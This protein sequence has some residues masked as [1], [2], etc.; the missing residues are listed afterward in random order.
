MLRVAMELQVPRSSPYQKHNNEIKGVMKLTERWRSGG[1]PLGCGGKA[2]SVTPRVRRSVVWRHQGVAFSGERSLIMVRPPGKCNSNDSIVLDANILR[3][4]SNSS[5]RGI[6][7]TTHDTNVQKKVKP[8]CRFVS[9]CATFLRLP[10][11][12]YAS[13]FASNPS[14][15]RCVRHF[16]ATVPY[17]APDVQ[18]CR[19][20][21]GTLS[22]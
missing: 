8:I 22:R 10:R 7:W 1:V 2:Y 11:T 20:T 21:D 5:T 14:L 15:R 9:F 6:A 4:C 3:C 18:V 13:D 16:R 12:G 17:A 19:A